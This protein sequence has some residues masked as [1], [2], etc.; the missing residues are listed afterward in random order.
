MRTLR[1]R[2]PTSMLMVFKILDKIGR[3]I[4]PDGRYCPLYLSFAPSARHPGPAPCR[5]PPLPWPRRSRSTL[6]AVHAQPPV[7][8]QAPPACEG[9]RHA[10]LDARGTADPRWGGRAVV[11]ERRTRPSA[12]SR[13]LSRASSRPWITRRR[14]RW[15]T[16]RRFTLANALVKIAPGGA[17][18]CVLHQLRLRGGRHGAENRPRLAPRA[19]RSHAHAPHRPRARLSRR[20][21]RRYLGWRHL[22]EPQDLVGKPAARASITCRTRMIWRTTPSRAARRSTARTSRTSSSGSW[23][24]TTLP[25]S[26]R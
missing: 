1:R 18:S 11:R 6:A 7:Q 10:L 25:T 17:R 15:R 12:K 4:V 8:V 26:P 16:R 14:F 23:R 19:R 5:T 9:E 20:G 13:R 3:N 21:L 22:A 24:C 2:A